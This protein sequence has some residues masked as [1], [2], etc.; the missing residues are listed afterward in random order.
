M[1]RVMLTET[2]DYLRNMRPVLLPPAGP[3]ELPHSEFRVTLLPG[4]CDAEWLRNE[5]GD[6]LY[7]TSIACGA[8]VPLMEV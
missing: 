5:L 7:E 8:I 1:S 3:V 4:S 6:A 2:I